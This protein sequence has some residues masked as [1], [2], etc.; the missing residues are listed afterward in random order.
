MWYAGSSFLAYLAGV[1]VEDS[2]GCGA[3]HVHKPAGIH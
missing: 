2:G 3:G 1:K